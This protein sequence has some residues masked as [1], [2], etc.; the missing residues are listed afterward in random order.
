VQ[1]GGAIGA[2]VEENIN[3]VNGFDAAIIVKRP[4]LDLLERLRQ[5]GVPVIWDI[6]DSWPQPVGNEWTHEQCVAWLRNE[7]E[8]VQPKAIVAATE[9]MAEDCKDF[10]VPVL[11]LPHHHRPGIK[12][13]PIRERVR[14]VGYEGGEQYLG[15]WAPA[16]TKACASRGW[17]FVVNPEHLADVDIVV[18][19]RH[20]QGYAAKSW[21]SAV[22]LE[23]SRGSGTPCILN[24]ERGYVELACGVEKWADTEAQLQQAFDGLV[25]TDARRNI[26]TELLKSALHLDEIAKRYKE[27]LEMI[28]MSTSI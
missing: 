24:R 18:A 5:R 14:T 27:W 11:A 20:H 7:F 12:R 8:T 1:L 9:Q 13:N 26:H 19:V 3:K 28:F 23:N 15:W 16:L 22:K 2:H 10:G 4:R 21:K 6:V 17:T 25:S